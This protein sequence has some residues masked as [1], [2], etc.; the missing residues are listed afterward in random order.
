MLNS[1]DSHPPST[2][3][4]GK[5]AFWGWPAL[6]LYLVGGQSLLYTSGLGAFSLGGPVKDNVECKPLRLEQRDKEEDEKDQGVIG[7]TTE[8]RKSRSRLAQTS[9]RRRERTPTSIKSKKRRRRR[10]RCLLPQQA[11]RS[12]VLSQCDLFWVCPISTPG[13][14]AVCSRAKISPFSIRSWSFWMRRTDPSPACGSG[15]LISAS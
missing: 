10:R 1:I 5:H 6:C 7:V 12:R 15:A 3:P 13:S 4:P 9:P 8:V 2:L 14:P 11:T